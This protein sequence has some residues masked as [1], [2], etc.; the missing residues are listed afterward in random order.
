M[1]HANNARRGGGG[2]M[3]RS[4]SKQNLQDLHHF[5]VRHI[6][7]GSFSRTLQVFAIFNQDLYRKIY[8]FEYLTVSTHLSSYV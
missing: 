4:S 2:L 6:F 1:S 5:E 7:K 3:A 8:F